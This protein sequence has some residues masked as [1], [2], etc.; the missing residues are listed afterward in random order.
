MAETLAT[1]DNVEAV[2]YD[3]SG[4]HHV[5]EVDSDTGKKKHLSSDEYLKQWGKD[6]SVRT[7]DSPEPVPIPVVEAPVE[8]PATVLPAVAEGA[9]SARETAA[10]MNAQVEA[11]NGRLD[12]I[13]PPN[14]QPAVPEAERKFQAGQK[15]KVVKGSENGDET[16]TGWEII[17]TKGRN[18]HGEIVYIVKNPDETETREISEPLL[19]NMQLAPEGEINSI[20]NQFD[21]FEKRF[22]ERFGE[23][24]AR[25]EARLGI[26]APATIKRPKKDDETPVEVAELADDRGSERKEGLPQDF[27]LRGTDHN[28]QRYLIRGRTDGGSLQINRNVDDEW[29]IV[30]GENGWFYMTR[31]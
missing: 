3:K 20:E 9:A 18:A 14:E 7:S 22:N 13:V 17:D 11:V 31:L 23:R 19:E 24:L 6:P 29:N 26:E 28:G 1:H 2:K 15:V 4:A 30:G 8:L 10:E 21:L 27:T 25:I 16:E 12:E 5:Y